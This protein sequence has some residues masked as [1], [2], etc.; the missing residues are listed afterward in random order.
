MA[1]IGLWIKGD[2][3]ARDT[4]MT[5]HHKLLSAIQDQRPQWYM[6]ETLSPDEHT[7][8]PVPTYQS[9]L[10]QLIFALLVAQQESTIDLNFRFQLPDAKYE[11]LASLVE[12]CRRV[13]LFNYPNMLSRFHPS[14]PIALIWVSVEEIKRFGLA[15]YKLCRLCTRTGLDTGGSSGGSSGGP[16]SEL[17]TLT[18]LDFCMP[19]SDEVWNA[20]PDTGTEWFRSSALQQSCRD[21][22]D[23]DGW[24]SQTAE[25]LHDGRVGLDWI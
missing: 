4:A 14:A 23:P 16:R 13:G 25:K 11:L 6:P 12:T 5:F 19:D 22:R 17:L 18:D 24:I 10:L 20:P 15:L 1:M 2:Q 21:N 3:A 7:A 8:W 9:I